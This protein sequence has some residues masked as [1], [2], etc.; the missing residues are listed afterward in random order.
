MKLSPEMLARATS[1]HPW[2]TVIGWG[3]A[4]ITA[5][6]LASSF[7]G[8]ALTTA[9]VRGQQSRPRPPTATESSRLPRPARRVERA[10]R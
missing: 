3:L 8:D 10:S 4:L 1:R 5:A 2:R 6:V 7:L 9:L